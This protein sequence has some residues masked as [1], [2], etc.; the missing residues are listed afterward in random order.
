MSASLPP[1]HDAWK[2]T[3]PDDDDDSDRAATPTKGGPMIAP[4]TTPSAAE[5]TE[6]AVAG[7]PRG[8]R[9]FLLVHTSPYTRN[10]LIAW[11]LAASP[12]DLDAAIGDAP[13]GAYLGH[14]RRVVTGWEAWSY[15]PSAERGEHVYAAAPY[16]TWPNDTA[17]AEALLRRHGFCP[18]ADAER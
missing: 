10:V 13:D 4:R 11:D 8:I 17:A 1:G 14:V 5:V 15:G 12:D 18:D 3:P 2:T 9:G 16:G 6:H 7:T